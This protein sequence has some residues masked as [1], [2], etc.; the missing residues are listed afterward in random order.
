VENSVKHGLAPKIEGGTVHL[1]SRREEHSLVVEVE[2]DGVGMAAA[3][4]LE[5]PTGVGGSGIGIANVAE[6]LKVLYG[7]AANLVIRGGNGGGTLVRLT[8]PLLATAE[9]SGYQEARASTSR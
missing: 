1:R 4:F 6:R 9:H 5:R 3:S 7:D 8:V 2:D